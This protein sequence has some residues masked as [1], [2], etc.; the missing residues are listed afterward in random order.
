MSVVLLWV[1]FEKVSWWFV[2][3]CWLIVY[4]LS[5]EFGMSLNNVARRLRI[6]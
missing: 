6:A 3:N 2:E 1:V 5:G 4:G